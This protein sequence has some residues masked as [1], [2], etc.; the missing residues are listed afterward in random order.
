[1]FA[2]PDLQSSIVDHEPLHLA[3]R[4][5]GRGRGRIDK[6]N[7]ADVFVGDEANVM[8]Q[9]TA[10]DVADLLDGGLGVNV[11]QIDGPVPQVGHATGRGGHGGGR[12]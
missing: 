4:V 10:D 12:H 11:A 8:Q 9:A 2:P 1:M 5:E 3:E 6:G 7:E